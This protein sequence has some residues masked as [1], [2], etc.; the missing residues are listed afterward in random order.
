MPVHAQGVEL[1]QSYFGDLYETVRKEVSIP[2]LL[3]GG[4]KDITDA[5]RLIGESR[6]DLISAGRALLKGPEWADRAFA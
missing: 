3:A 6:A 4:V 5:D 2:V 1:P